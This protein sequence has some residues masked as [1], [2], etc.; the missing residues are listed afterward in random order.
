[1]KSLAP[2]GVDLGEE[3]GFDFPEAQI[4]EVIAHDPGHA[5]TRAQVQLHLGSAKV[6]I[7]I[8]KPLVLGD[9][10]MFVGGERWRGEVLSTSKSFTR[11]SIS[12]VGSLGLTRSLPRAATTPVT[13]TTH[14]ERSFRD[15]S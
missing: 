13:L 2:S 6:Q 8:G 11:I 7:A 9:G 12:P 10:F 5:V 1:M 3:R 15:S 14:S 4:A